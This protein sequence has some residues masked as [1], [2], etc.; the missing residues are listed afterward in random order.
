MSNTTIAD[1]IY[2]YIQRYPRLST[3]ISVLLP[4]IVHYG[5]NVQVVVL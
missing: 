4:Y 2:H 1:C 3:F 5:G